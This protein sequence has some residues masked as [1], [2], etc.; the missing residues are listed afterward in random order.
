MRRRRIE[1]EKKKKYQVKI[2]LRTYKSYEKNYEDE[3][4]E[5]RTKINYILQR[6]R[7][8]EGESE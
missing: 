6:V 7:E 8:G 2:P 3:E 4:A 1:R 5:R